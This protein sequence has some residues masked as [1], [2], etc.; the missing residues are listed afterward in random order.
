MPNQADETGLMRKVAD[1]RTALTILVSGLLL[2]SGSLKAGVP[3]HIGLF[4]EFRR[5]RIPADIR[6]V[7]TSGHSATKIG[8]AVYE[9]L[10]VSSDLL[11][12]TSFRTRDALGHW[13]ELAE[14]RITPQMCGIVGTPDDHVTFH[15]WARATRELRREWVIPEGTYTLNGTQALA[16]RTGGRCY[17]TLLIPKNNSSFRI[18]FE[19]DL[20]GTAIETDGWRPLSRGVRAVGAHNAADKNL[21]INSTEVLIERDGGASDPYIKQELIRCGPDGSFSTPLVCSYDDPKAVMV[22]AHEPSLPIRVEGLRIRRTGSPGGALADRGV[23]VCERDR[24][25]F[26]DLTVSNDD[27]TQPLSVMVEIGYCADVTF[28]RPKI[29]GANDIANGLGYG[30]LFATTIGCRINHGRIL[31]CREAVSGRHNVDLHI[32]GGEYSCTI[33]DHWGD[34]MRIENVLIACAQGGAAVQYAGHDL[35]LSNVRQVNGRALLVIRDD[36]PSLSGAVTLLD[37]N[38]FSRGEKGD[39]YLFSFSSPNGPMRPPRLGSGKILLPD[40]LTIKGG[41]ID[42]DAPTTWIAY[43]AALAAPHRNWGRVNLSGEWTFKGNSLPVGVILFK[44]SSRQEERATEIIVDGPINFKNGYAVYVTAADSRDT[45][46]ASVQIT[47]LGGGNL[48]YSPYG[49]ASILVSGGRLGSIEND[50]SSEPV[51]RSS[52]L[53]SGVEMTGGF[54]RSTLGG[55]RFSDCVFTGSYAVFPSANVEMVRVRAAGKAALPA[56]VR[57]LIAAS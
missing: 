35:L 32:S 48:R 54:V 57:Q 23:V 42:V 26:N 37:S 30:L 34:R 43:L 33:D 19:R 10:P 14:E 25:T 44:D 49:V 38:V 13:W 1:R 31:D 29:Q 4:T 41:S 5:W 24:A 22:T 27:P 53:F 50:D 51:G 11:E 56:N 45:R 17:G 20:A 39:Y 12:E 7:R 16:L 47:N 9:R 2:P 8:S 3:L 18:V 36:T 6:T 40:S 15:E 52:S 21:F 46:A 55:L 28:N